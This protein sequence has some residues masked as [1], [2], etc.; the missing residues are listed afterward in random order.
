M[1]LWAKTSSPHAPNFQSQPSF[2]QGANTLWQSSKY[3]V[4][5]S[6]AVLLMISRVAEEAV[7]DVGTILVV[8]AVWC[9]SWLGAQPSPQTLRDENGIGVVLDSVVCR[10]PLAHLADLHPDL[11]E[12]PP[13]HPGARVLSLQL[14][15]LAEPVFHLNGHITIHERR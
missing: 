1:H 10:P 8:E 13:I 12:H 14:V 6:T 7:L 2:A 9:I 4:S 3:L 11:V 15:E 5:T